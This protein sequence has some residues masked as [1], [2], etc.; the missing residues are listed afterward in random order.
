MTPDQIAVVQTSFAKVVPISETAADLFY[1]RLFEIAPQVKPLFQSTDIKEQGKKLMATLA[2]VVGGLN[3]LSAILPAAKALAVRHVDYGVKAEDYGPVGEALIWTLGQGLGEDFTAETRDAWLA[4][5][6][7]LSD[8][9]ITE[10]Y[11]QA[12]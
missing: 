4:A 10:A 5:Y 3:D 7:A 9:M 6:S 11:G 2:F 1:G 8:V 12:A